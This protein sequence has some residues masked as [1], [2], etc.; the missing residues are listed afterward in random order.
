[1]EEYVKNI[2][3]KIMVIIGLMAVGHVSAMQQAVGIDNSQSE[4]VMFKPSDDGRLIKAPL[5]Q[6]RLF[7]TIK[8][9]VKFGSEEGSERGL[10][11]LEIPVSARV[12]E[13]L[14][15]DLRWVLE[16]QKA[17]NGGEPMTPEQVLTLD[18]TV[19]AKRAEREARAMPVGIYTPQYLTT[20]IEAY[21]AADYL[22]SPELI[23]KY[24]YEIGNNVTSHEALTLLAKNDPKLIELISDSSINQ[25]LKNIIFNHMRQVWIEAF[26][27][28]HN[29][30]VTSVA[31]SADGNRVV[32]GSWDNTAKIVDWNGAAWGEVYTIAHG[33]WA[34]SV[35]ISADSNK[36]VTGAIDGTAIVTWNGTAWKEPYTNVCSSAE[37]VAISKNGNRVVMGNGHVAAIVTWNGNA[38]VKRTFGCDSKVASVAISADG[39]TVVTG[40]QDGRAR[41]VVWDG[42]IWRGRFTAEHN[43]PVESVAISANGNT[44]VT[45]S[46]GGTAK[47]VRWNGDAWAEHIIAHRYGVSS[48][49][50]SADGNRVVTRS[51]PDGV[52]VMTWNGTVWVEHIMGVRDGVGPVAISADGNTMVIESGDKTT[53]I[54]QWSGTAWG[55]PH[56]IAQGTSVSSVVISADGNRVV[57]GSDNGTAK[58]V[59]LLPAYTFDQVLLL[60]LCIWM[61]E[62]GRGAAWSAG[63]GRRVMDTHGPA[64]KALIKNAFP[65]APQT[66]M[67]KVRGFMGFNDS[68]SS[69]TN[70]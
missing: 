32:T 40:S 65:K 27:A 33:G 3:F 60:Q 64:D 49:A 10:E 61:K 21:K 58:I 41:I 45:R 70:N 38:W 29:D 43:H 25:H 63:W 24:M 69:N 62:H 16:L 52:K 39:N 17:Y 53:K 28:Q 68:L 14:L 50:I 30:L 35:A 56:T 34:R 37:S 31:I 2:F 51:Y 54:I 1:M 23:K 19:R 20:L 18:S 12:S 9:A 36:V 13:K 4:L 67:Q 7:G 22:Q 46:E 15:K 55:E 59:Q 44:V 8:D 6:A 5:E 11:I 47:I 57:T 26:I 42:E 48:V 66:L